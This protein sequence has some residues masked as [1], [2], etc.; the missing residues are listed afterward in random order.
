MALLTRPG[1]LA[2]AVTAVLTTAPAARADT[3]RFTYVSDWG[4][5]GFVVDVGPWAL[6]P[7][8]GPST[9]DGSITFH[10]GGTSFRLRLDDAVTQDGATVP[11]TVSQVVGRTRTSRELCLAIG[12][13]HTI[14]LLK[15]SPM[16][17]LL[18]S[19]PASG[20]R[21]Y[22]PATTTAGSGVVTWG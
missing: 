17:S 5:G 10:P 3:L 12:R 21:T 22:C 1:L 15:G 13:T 4:G 16:V 14:G 19:G 9:A 6:E 2:L 8:I 18:L 20:R 11:V 7:V